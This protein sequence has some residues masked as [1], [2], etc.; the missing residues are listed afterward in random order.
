MK[1]LSTKLLLILIALIGYAAMLFSGQFMFLIT[2][3]KSQLKG[4]YDTLSGIVTNFHISDWLINYEGGF[5]RRG[6]I[7]EVL[8]WI[9]NITNINIPVFITILAFCLLL[10]FS[11]LFVKKWM[12]Y[13]LS[14]VL[15]PTFILLGGLWGSNSFMWFRRDILIYLLVWGAYSCYSNILKNRKFSV[16]L[17]HLVSVITILSHEASFFYMLPIVLFHYIL[18]NRQNYNWKQSIQKA[19]MLSFPS[20]C[21]FLL[22]SVFKGNSEV[23]KTIW[24]SWHPLFTQLRIEDVP[25]GLG[26]NALSWDTIAT[27]KNHATLNFIKGEYGIPGFLLWPIVYFSILYFLININKIGTVT[28]IGKE[29]FS[30]IKYLHILLVISIFMLPM[31]TVLSCDNKRVILYCILSSFIFYFSLSRQQ[32]CVFYQKSISHFIKQVCLFFTHG[33]LAKKWVF[34]LFLLFAGMPSVYFSFEGIFESSIVG[35]PINMIKQ[36]LCIFGI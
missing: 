2:N 26:P 4:N 6:I 31:F 25:L 24:D 30:I 20:V 32:L 27:F 7:G 34:I 35:L 17:F 12:H 33:L 23:A 14:L 8:Y 10:C 15:L 22:C 16:V 9:Y 36:A 5:V 29:P 3:C 19:T 13:R 21:T 11:V 18:Y 28:I 1:R